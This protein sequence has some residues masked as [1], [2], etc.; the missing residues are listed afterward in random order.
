MIDLVGYYGKDVIKKAFSELEARTKVAKLMASGM[1]GN[2]KTTW[3]AKDPQNIPSLLAR[4]LVCS[5]NC[6]LNSF[7]SCDSSLL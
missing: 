7:Y 5:C 4:A 2:I 1:S 6:F 3:A